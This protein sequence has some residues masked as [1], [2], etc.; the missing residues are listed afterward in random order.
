MK[1]KQNSAFYAIYVKKEENENWIK[2]KEHILGS[3]E[4]CNEFVFTITYT[5]KLRLRIRCWGNLAWRGVVGQEDEVDRVDQARCCVSAALRR[6]RLIVPGPRAHTFTRSAHPRFH[7][8]SIP[9]WLVFCLAPGE[10]ASKPA[11]STRAS[12]IRG[13][14]G[15]NLAFMSLK[16]GAN[17]TLNALTVE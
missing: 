14:I 15:N 2:N 7:Q 13:E 17:G 9:G 10:A 6:S 16:A 4:S 8:T 1:N 12:L 11:S 3:K 5:K